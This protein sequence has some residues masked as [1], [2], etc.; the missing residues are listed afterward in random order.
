MTP[1]WPR[2]TSSP[3]RGRSRNPSRNLEP[4]GQPPP[5]REDVVHLLTIARRLPRSLPLLLAL[6]GPLTAQTADSSLLSLE[7]IYT[8]TE[9]R[10]EFFGPARWLAGG[11]AYTT[12]ERSREGKGGQDLVRYDVETGTRTVLVPATRL[13]P[14][15]DTL[16][17]T[18]ENYV[19]SA[20]EQQ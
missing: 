12:L 15:G 2:W 1:C 9:F 16:P 18:V 11:T 5:R 19:W 17:L 7:R 8:S 6:V 13:I 10:P 14:A 3:A 20:D 4:E